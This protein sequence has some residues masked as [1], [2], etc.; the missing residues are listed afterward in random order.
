MQKY[1]VGQCP[2]WTVIKTR[3]T[4]S[5]PRALCEKCIANFTLCI[6]C[7]GPVSLRL[8]K[9]FG[10][11]KCGIC[12][13]GKCKPTLDLQCHHCVRW[14]PFPL[15]KTICSKGNN[16]MARCLFDDSRVPT[17]TRTIKYVGDGCYCYHYCNCFVSGL[18]KRPGFIQAKKLVDAYWIKL[19]VVRRLLIPDVANQIVINLN[20]IVSL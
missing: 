8:Y 19:A 12:Y 2:C 18:S 13:N 11:T 15:N 14:T 7:G 6:C 16:I 5:L 9:R 3:K 17:C 10:G 20:F 1:Y 4:N